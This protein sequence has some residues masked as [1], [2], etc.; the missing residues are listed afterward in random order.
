MAAI[1]IIFVFAFAEN[2]VLHHAAGFPLFLTGTARPPTNVL[3]ILCITLAISGFAGWAIAQ[4]FSVIL[5]MEY[6][7]TTLWVMIA[8]IVPALARRFAK[9]FN[10]F[11]EKQLR[12]FMVPQIAL[13]YLL[14]AWNL[15]GV[16]AFLASVG[17]AAGFFVLSKLY[18]A[19]MQRLMYENIPKRIRGLP[20]AF[21]VMGTLSM[22]C[23]LIEVVFGQ[24][25][26]NVLN[27]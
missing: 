19:I 9:A 21:F 10:A 11:D 8:W 4:V 18:A 17:S 26:W 16:F 15:D 2:I 7:S 1:A 14:S 23:L 22:A 20:L 25:I 13:M 5:H 3:L 12:N 6:I 24:S 27:A